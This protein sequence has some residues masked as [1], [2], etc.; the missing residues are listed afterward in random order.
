MEIQ[1]YLQLAAAAGG[2]RKGGDTGDPEGAYSAD[3]T[4]TEHDDSGYSDEDSSD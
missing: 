3:D 1:W 4:D 2:A